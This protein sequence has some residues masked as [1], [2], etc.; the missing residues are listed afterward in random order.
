MGQQ[1]IIKH[2]AFKHSLH[3]TYFKDRSKHQDKKISK[4]KTKREKQDYIERED[5]VTLAAEQGEE[6]IAHVAP[7]TGPLG[8]LVPTGCPKKCTN[9][10]KS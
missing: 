7:S 8:W 6:E 5:L 10:T 1:H 4:T 9:K 3:L 2:H